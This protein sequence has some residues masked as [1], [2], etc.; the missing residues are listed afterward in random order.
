MKVHLQDYDDT[1]HAMEIPD[2]SAIAQLLQSEEGVMTVSI[3][4]ISD[5]ATK[6]Y[7]RA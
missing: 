6:F 4:R 3:E 5:G 7:Q 2:D 1:H